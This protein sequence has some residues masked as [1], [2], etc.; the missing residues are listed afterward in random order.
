MD[1]VRLRELDYLTGGTEMYR[2]M[3]VT[4]GPGWTKLSV[5]VWEHAATGI[6]IHTGG[7]IVGPDID[8]STNS[9]PY[10]HDWW[11]HTRIAGGSRKRGLM[12]LALDI[13]KGG[14]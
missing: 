14:A 9:W 13:L 4:P 6:R 2:V 10:S 12:T 5:S 3:R 7:L 1:P 11:Q 8:V